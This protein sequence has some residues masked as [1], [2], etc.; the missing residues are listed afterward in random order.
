MKRWMMYLGL[1][2][3]TV[4]LAEEGV[5]DLDGIRLR[6]PKEWKN[7]EASSSFRLAQFVLQRADGDGVDATCVIFRFGGGQGGGL[8]AN[9]NRY[10]GQFE[11]PDG[12][13]TKDLA[14][15]TK[16][17]VSGI[18]I[19]IAD[20]SGTYI[21]PKRPGAPERFN[22]PNWRMLVAMLTVNENSY[23]IRAVGPQKTIARWEKSFEE[24]IGSLQKAKLP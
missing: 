18:P 10:Y 12:R 3:A 2:V 11:Q 14:K 20:I 9:L 7:E 13:A 16:R 17:E 19:T 22:E 6:A 21:A 24:F 23:F 15:T 8:E 4:S 1:V 5:L